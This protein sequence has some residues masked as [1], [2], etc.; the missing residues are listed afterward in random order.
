MQRPPSEVRFWT[1]D[2][3]P[4]RAPFFGVRWL[5]HRFYT[6]NKTTQPTSSAP[7]PIRV[8]PN[9]RRLR[10]RDLLFLQIETPPP[11]QK[12]ATQRVAFPKT[13]K[14][15]IYLF[16][17]SSSLINASITGFNISCVTRCITSG[18]I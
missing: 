12:K 10:M 4:E 13:P 15:P 5:C 8:I 11:T 9:P 18:L 7:T 6:A 1:P 16:D 14:I 17:A 3:F 2:D